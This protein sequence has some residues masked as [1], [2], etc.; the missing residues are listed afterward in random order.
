[1]DEQLARKRIQSCPQARHT[2]RRDAGLTGY[3]VETITIRIAADDYLVRTLSDRQQFSDPDGLAERA[4]ISSATWP[5]FGMVWPAGLA[6]AEEMSRFPVE[7]LRIL[8]VGCGLGFASLVLQKR[9]ADITATD[10]HPLA[11]EF[12]LHNAALNGLSAIKYCDAPWIASNPRLGDFDLIVGSDVLYER[13]HP[14]LLA[15]FL[16]RHAKPAA[17]VLIADPGRG[18]RGPFSKRMAEQGYSRSELLFRAGGRE[19]EGKGRI[20]NFLRGSG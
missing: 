17:R 7:G 16:A 1:M 2:N 6:L 8:E 20:L 3:N 13:D 4:G 5:L 11:E 19:V 15:D 9:G 12:L 14:A 18:Y 10:N